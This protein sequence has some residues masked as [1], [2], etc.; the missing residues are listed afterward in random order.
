MLCHIM[1]YEKINSEVTQN[2]LGVD[3]LSNWSV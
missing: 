1:W 2:A 3:L